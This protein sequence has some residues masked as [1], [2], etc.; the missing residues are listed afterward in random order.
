MIKMRYFSSKAVAATCGAFLL[1]ALGFV[2]P[3]QA[4][5]QK[6]RLRSQLTP[7]CTQ[8]RSSTGWKFADLYGDGNIAVQGSYGCNGVFIYDVTD[9]DA[10]ILASV[11]NPGNTYQFLEAV[12]IGNRGYFGIGAQGTS[13]STGDGVHIV[14][15]SNP[16]NPVLLGKVNTTTVANSWPTIHEIMVIDQGANRYLIENSNVT[17]N[18]NVR[19]IDVTNPASPVFKWQFTQVDAGWVHAIHIRGNRMYTS[20]YTSSTTEIYDISNLGTAAPTRI[21]TINI[22]S[23]TSHSTWTSEDG[24]YL[25]SCRETL[26]GDV[27]VYDVLNPAAP[28]LLKSIKAGDLNINA[29]TPHNP[30]VMGDLLYVSWYQAGVQVFDI[31]NPAD[32]RRVGQYDTFTPAFAPTDEEK[33]FLETLDPW[34]VVCGTSFSGFALPS[35]YDGNWAVFPFLGQ[36]KV[37]AGDLT[38]GLLVLDASRVNAPRKNLVTDFDGDGKTDLSLYSPSTGVW[39]GENS[40][41]GQTFLTQFGTAEDIIQSGDFDG[42][43][44]TDLAVF[45]PSSGLWFMMRS[46]AGFNA[47]QFGQQG[48]VPVAADFDADGRTDIAVWRPSNGIWFLLQSSLGFRAF[49]WGAVGDKPLIGDY[50]GDGKIDFTVWRP[51][52]GVW[53]T[54]PSSS[55]IPMYAQFGQNGDKPVTGDVTGNGITDY[56]IYRPSTGQ[57]FILDPITREFRVYNF[58]IS[59]DVP[60]PADYDGDER[61][62]IAVYR[63]STNTWYRLNSSDGQFFYR[64]FGS[65]GDKPA[66]AAIQ[67]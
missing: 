1:L 52:N 59:E 19:I 32:P 14:D 44:K 26:D 63:P 40:S 55:S 22:G 16:Y 15:L 8:V 9:P 7:N 56:V 5:A 65:A 35:S 66:P 34:D 54:I 3:E 50:E 51:S 6:V 60:V 67:P 30:V 53:Y 37:L 57:W 36:N 17:S 48:D 58:G 24:R 38:A 61:A 13:T 64:G 25:Y 11:Y 12:V 33:K 23:T 27:R 42:D 28:V 31:S 39:R 2:L 20:A 29:V 43:G 46:S 49:Q 41:N 18:K 21:G 47:V 62:D 10:P 45:R 4:V